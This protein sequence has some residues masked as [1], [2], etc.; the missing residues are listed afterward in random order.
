MIDVVFISKQPNALTT[1]V[2][3]SL[4]EWQVDAYIAQA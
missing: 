2:V 3:A 1:P 4:P